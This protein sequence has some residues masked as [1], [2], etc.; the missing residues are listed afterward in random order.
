ML[1][2]KLSHIIK[3]CPWEL[4]IEKGFI[5]IVHL[6]DKYRSPNQLTAAMNTQY[7]LTSAMINEHLG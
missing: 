6:S 2:L 5:Y 3:R 7:F 4:Q 1:R